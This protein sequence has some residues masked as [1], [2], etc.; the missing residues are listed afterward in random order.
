MHA[1]ASWYVDG[2]EQDCSISI[3]NDTAVLYYAIGIKLAIDVI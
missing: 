2:L 1:I 3:A